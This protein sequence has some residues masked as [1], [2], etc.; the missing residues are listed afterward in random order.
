MADKLGER[1]YHDSGAHEEME[2]ALREVERLVAGLG[3][4]RLLAKILAVKIAEEEYV[5]ATR[6]KDALAF[7]AAF[8][9]FTAAVAAARLP[10]DVRAELSTHVGALPRSLRAISCE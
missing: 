6:D 2:A 5:E 10:H 7:T 3:S 4:D 1:G 9:D 8:R